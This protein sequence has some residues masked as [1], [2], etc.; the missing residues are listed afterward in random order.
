MKRLLA[1]LAVLALGAGSSGLSAAERSVV[2]KVDNMTCSLCA[3]TVQQAL[4]GVP[5]VKKVSVLRGE[6]TATVVYDDAA[7]TVGELAEASTNA[8]YPARPIA[9]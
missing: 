4:E 9:Q 5:G 8:G 1:V 3:L 6:D 7:T 2:L